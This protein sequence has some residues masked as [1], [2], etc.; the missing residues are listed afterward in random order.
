MNNTIKF[1]VDKNNN[2]K[3]LDLFLAQNLNDFTRS[4]LKKLIEN[5]IKKLETRRFCKK[6]ARRDGET[7]KKLCVSNLYLLT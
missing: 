1:S 3:R 6:L 5:N 2:G 4:F 7:T